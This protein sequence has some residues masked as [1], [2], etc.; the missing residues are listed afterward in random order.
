MT[1]AP[2]LKPYRI[3]V[4]MTCHNR[5]LTT[6]KCL[7]A[8]KNQKGLGE[9]FVRVFLVD[10]GSTDG[11][12]EIVSAAHPEVTIIPGDGSLYWCGGMRVAWAEAAKEDYDYYLWLNDDTHIFQGTIH[13][14][15]QTSEFLLNREGATVILAGATCSP[16][17][18]KCTYGGVNK[19][20][21]FTKPAFQRINPLEHPQQCDT[22]NGNC[23]LVP[24]DVAERVGNLSAAFTHGIGDFD[25]G[26]RAGR[27]GI[28]CWLDDG[29][30]G[31]C[32][33]K[34]KVGGWQDQDLPMSERI[35]AMNQPTGLPP[36]HEWMRFTW[37]HAGW[38]WPVCW[39]RS[40][41]GFL[42][43]GLRLRRHL[44]P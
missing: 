14:L 9:T 22:I 18:N 17:T 28:Q 5:R 43:P 26:L 36:I 23:V 4:L 13:K 6:L 25:Y 30:I 40:I 19:N 37:R 31:E 2:F 12:S 15:V 10:D 3:A 29:F 21:F 11:T 1:T 44:K 20:G 34:A 42:F 24:R 38:L 41:V 7:D 39:A 8:I 27:F 33:A 32:S 16:N 35:H